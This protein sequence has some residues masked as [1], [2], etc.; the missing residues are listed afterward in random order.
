M[1]IFNSMDDAQ[2]LV[3]S[4]AFAGLLCAQTLL[5]PT[6]ARAIN[7]GKTPILLAQEQHVRIATL[8]CGGYTITIRTEGSAASDSYSYHTDGLFLRNGIREDE[9]YLFYNNDH[10]YKVETR[11]GGTGRL[12]VSHYGE[13]IM[14]KQCTWS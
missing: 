12:T 8:Q 2:Q 10:E 9:T 4:I 5:A 13:R 3:G 14:T 6:A 1:T 7:S 11:S